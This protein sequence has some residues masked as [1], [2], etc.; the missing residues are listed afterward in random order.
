M[1]SPG[2][3]TLAGWGPLAFEAD[4]REHKAELL[5]C[6]GRGG[7]VAIVWA[8]WDAQRCPICDALGVEFEH[9]AEIVTDANERAIEAEGERDGADGDR[10]AA[11]TKLEGALQALD[12]WRKWRD[13]APR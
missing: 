6:D 11:E 2:A 5:T 8:F 12:A 13:A 3:T 4:E 7:H 9:I 1:A 10:E